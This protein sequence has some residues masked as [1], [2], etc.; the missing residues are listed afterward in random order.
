MNMNNLSVMRIMQESCSKSKEKTDIIMPYTALHYILSGS[1]YFNQVKLGAGQF[2]CAVKDTKVC[3][4]PCYEEPWTYIYID[5]YSE[6]SKLDS[7]LKWGLDV[8]APY[9]QFDFMEEL[10]KIYGFYEEYG[11]HY[12]CNNE[13]MTS[14]ARMILSLHK[15]PAQRDS[16]LAHKHVND[17]KEYLDFNFY[18]KIRIEDL[19]KE[20]YLSRQYLRNLFDQYLNMSPKQYLQKVRMEKASELL[21][22]TQYSVALVAYSIGYDDQLAFSKMFQSYYGLSPTQYR[23]ANAM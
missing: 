22:N 11:R 3:Y 2:F 14:A 4:F 16:S 15:T 1:G 7:L 18:K 9:G 19:A 17:I 6:K 13:F 21:V 10:K 23:K 20:F 5:F 8:N 12:I